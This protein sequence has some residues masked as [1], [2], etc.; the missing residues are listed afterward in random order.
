MITHEQLN[1]L[2]QQRCQRYAE[3]IDDEIL[4]LTLA[5]LITSKQA[6]I[7]FHHQCIALA[8]VAQRHC[9]GEERERIRKMFFEVA[10]QGVAMSI[11]SDKIGKKIKRGGSNEQEIH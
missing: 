1:K 3:L 9:V 8:G 4:R 11:I 2:T 10:Y 6:I 7:T 5:N